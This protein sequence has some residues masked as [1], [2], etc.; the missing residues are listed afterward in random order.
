M[1]TNQPISKG[2][3]RSVGRHVSE[4]GTGGALAL[5]IV[6]FTP[7]GWMDAFQMN[8]SG[9]VLTGFFSTIAK[10]ASERGL[11]GG[12]AKSGLVLLLAG[13]MGCAGVVG[14]VEPTIHTG[15]DGETVVACSVTGIAWSGGDADICRNLES[16]HVGRDFV[17]MILGIFRITGAAVGGFFGGL[18]GAGQGV[19]AAVNAVPPLPE[20]TATQPAVVYQANPTSTEDG[21]DA[22]SA[23]WFE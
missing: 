23:D 2:A 13:T 15:A 9:V 8:L 17:N 14:R 12:V 5:L 4:L 10:V 18:G 3:N 6:S 7:E 22:P 20:E 19:V 21:G 11:L 1:A 16:G